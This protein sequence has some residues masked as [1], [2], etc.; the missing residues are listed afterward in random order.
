MQDVR[1]E[2]EETKQRERRGYPDLYNEYGSAGGVVDLGSTGRDAVRE[3][4]W[5]GL[6]H[7]GR[8]LLDRCIG[9]GV[10]ALDDDVFVGGVPRAVLRTR[11]QRIAQVQRKSELQNREEQRDQN[12]RYQ[13]EVDDG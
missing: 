4:I 10:I 13:D 5:Q 2:P 11:R 7:A 6:L 3:R 9:H 1:P 8:R 12:E